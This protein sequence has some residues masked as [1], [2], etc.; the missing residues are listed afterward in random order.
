M[1]QKHDNKPLEFFMEVC[2]QLGTTIPIK[3]REKSNINIFSK[4]VY[5]FH[6]TV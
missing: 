6:T 1:S 2:P 5:H 4:E 3:T